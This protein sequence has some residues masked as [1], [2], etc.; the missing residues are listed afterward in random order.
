MLLLTFSPLSLSLTCGISIQTNH[1]CHITWLNW[2]IIFFLLI[3]IFSSLSPCWFFICGGKWCKLIIHHTVQW[4][5]WC[6]WLRLRSDATRVMGPDHWVRFWG[7]GLTTSS[8]YEL[9]GLPHH[10]LCAALHSYVGAWY[11][12]DQTY[13]DSCA[14]LWN[15]GQDTHAFEPY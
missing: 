15:S 11:W 3:K 2:E 6:T 14:L 8:G 10:H 5:F 9:A 12:T 7:G 13:Q 4:Y 1:M